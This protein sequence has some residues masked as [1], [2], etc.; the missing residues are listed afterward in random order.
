LGTFVTW[1][2]AVGNLIT[3]DF[4]TV[5]NIVA[6]GNFV[7]WKLCDWKFCELGIE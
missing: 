5:G 3:W 1:T 7:T 2:L 6:I 4:V